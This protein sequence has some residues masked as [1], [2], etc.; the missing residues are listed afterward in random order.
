[1]DWLNTDIIYKRLNIFSYVRVVQ[2][3]GEMA[4]GSNRKV[5]RIS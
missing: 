4:H 2:F 3:V 5:G 1:M